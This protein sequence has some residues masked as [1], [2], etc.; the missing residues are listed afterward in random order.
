MNRIILGLLSAIVT[1]T[2]PAAEP[3]TNASDPS[4]A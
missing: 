3:T 4:S 1:S 2:S